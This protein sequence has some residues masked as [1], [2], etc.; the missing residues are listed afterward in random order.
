MIET[1]T[2]TIL[3]SSSCLEFQAFNVNARIKLCSIAHFLPQNSFIIVL[4]INF[5]LHLPFNMRFQSLAL[6]CIYLMGLVVYAAPVPR[7]HGLPPTLAPRNSAKLE[8]TKITFFY[9]DADFQRAWMSTVV[10]SPANEDRDMKELMRQAINR[11]L[12]GTD[13]R[14]E[15]KSVDVGRFVYKGK[16]KGSQAGMAEFDIETKDDK[17]KVKEHKG[18]EMIVNT[19]RMSV[20]KLP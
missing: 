17:G 16:K 19:M 15:K 6:I 5:T 10:G 1:S 11:Y 4:G 18:G 20:E 7:R 13:T 2:P 12:V 3:S 9:S 8:I 14:Y